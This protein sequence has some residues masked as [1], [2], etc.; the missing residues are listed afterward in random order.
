[1]GLFGDSLRYLEHARAL[2]RPEDHV[3]RLRVLAALG[4]IYWQTGQPEQALAALREAHDLAQ[5]WGDP[6]QQLRILFWLGYV[7]AHHFRTGGDDLKQSHAYLQQA[8]SIAE[9][10]DHRR[11]MIAIQYGLGLNQFSQG[12]ADEARAAY[13]QSI[14]TARNNNEL[15][16]FACYA[17]NDMGALS[18]N[19]GNLRQA[20]LYFEQCCQQTRQM[21]SLDYVSACGNLGEIARLQGDLPAALTY[22]EDAL[23]LAKQSGKHMVIPIQYLNMALV[24]LMQRQPLKA[25]PHLAQGVRHL[26]IN[27]TETDALL[28]MLIMAGIYAMEE[29]YDTALRWFGYVASR[30]GLQVWGGD[31][32]AVVHAILREK[33]SEEEI[34]RSLA[35]STLL[36]LDTVW[37]SVVAEIDIYEQTQAHITKEVPP[38][39]NPGPDSDQP[40]PTA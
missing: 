9:H 6:E 7:M 23:K 15:S 28:A 13:L 24:E 20:K 18:V 5:T 16:I 40:K 33:F 4:E 35:R 12:N 8:L 10:I 17:L 26:Q 32:E 2:L 21:G 14:A 22:Y 27:F 11:G 25:L 38:I 29:E 3:L 19:A 30:P 36:D 34:Q 39:N 1:M 31:D 37:A